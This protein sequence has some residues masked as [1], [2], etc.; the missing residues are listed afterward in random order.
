[1]WVVCGLF[2]LAFLI[3]ILLCL[4]MACA[5]FLF[6]VPYNAG[7]IHTPVVV[8]SINI[9]RWSLVAHCG[10]PTHVSFQ[11]YFVFGFDLFTCKLQRWR[12]FYLIVFPCQ[13]F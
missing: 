2:S 3:V 1:M 13:S 12:L 6:F 9:F 7:E 8:V 11:R 10:R 5:W 4:C